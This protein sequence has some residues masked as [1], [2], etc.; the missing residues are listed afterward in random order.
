MLTPAHLELIFLEVI[1]FYYF[2]GGLHW[3]FIVVHRLFLVV[4]EPSLVSVS[5]LLFVAERR[6]WSVWAQGFRHVSSLVMACGLS[7]REACGIL[8]IVL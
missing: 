5:G 1:L 7:C 2:A 8:L 6:L 3:V 4:P